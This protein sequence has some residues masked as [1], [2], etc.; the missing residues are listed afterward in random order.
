MSEKESEQLGN[1]DEE[2]LCLSQSALAALNEFLA[3]KKEREEK[4]QAIAQSATENSSDPSKLLDE[5]DL[6]EDW[7]KQCYS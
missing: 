5:V 3:E 6:D 1:E 7:V 4:L 2:E